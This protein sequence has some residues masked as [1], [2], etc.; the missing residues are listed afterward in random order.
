VAEL[1]RHVDCLALLSLPREYV[2]AMKGIAPNW[3]QGPLAV[4]AMDSPSRQLG[5]LDPLLDAINARLVVFIEDLDRNTEIPDVS[6][7]QHVRTEGTNAKSDIRNE[8]AGRPAG[9]SFLEIES[10][11][12]RMKESRRVSFVLA[13]SRN[14]V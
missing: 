2:G 6:F 12:D 10:L 4:T 8:I 5:R 9:R 13:V 3:L 11:L 7:V 14:I 1:S